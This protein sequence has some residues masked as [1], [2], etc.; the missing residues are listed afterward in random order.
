MPLGFVEDWGAAESGGAG[1]AEVVRR[2]D[3]AKRVPYERGNRV[4]AAVGLAPERMRPRSGVGAWVSGSSRLGGIRSSDGMAQAK[5]GVDRSGTEPMNEGRTER[6]RPGSRRERTRLAKHDRGSLA[7]LGR[8]RITLEAQEV[9]RPLHEEAEPQGQDRCDAAV[10]PFVSQIYLASIAGRIHFHTMLSLFPE[11]STGCRTQGSRVGPPNPRA[12][13]SGMISFL[14]TAGRSLSSS[15]VLH[16]SMTKRK[17]I[18]EPPDH[19]V[20][21]W[22]RPGISN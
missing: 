20:R 6:S 22:G 7:R 4:G 9:R 15:S 5:P 3:P 1:R 13:P 17:S 12:G 10:D 16:R 8:R 11:L 2:V 14:R 21:A 18:G 19:D